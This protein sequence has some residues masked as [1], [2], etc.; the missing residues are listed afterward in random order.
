MGWDN[1][2]DED[3]SYM[4]LEVQYYLWFDPMVIIVELCRVPNIK[5]RANVYVNKFV[6]DSSS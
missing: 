2:D 1:G 3:E 4:D 5:G 6:T